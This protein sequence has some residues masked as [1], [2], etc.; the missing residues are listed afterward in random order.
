MIKLTKMKTSYLI[1]YTEPIPVPAIIFIFLKQLFFLVHI[2]M[3]NLILGLG[4]I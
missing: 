4:L 2:I 3:I 1:P